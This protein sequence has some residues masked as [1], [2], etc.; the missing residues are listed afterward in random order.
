MLAVSD[1]ETIE[2]RDVL[3]IFLETLLTDLDVGVEPFALCY[4]R[5]RWEATLGN[6][7]FASVHYAGLSAFAMERSCR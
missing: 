5:G 2:S 6:K 7:R 3:A 4:V 1:L